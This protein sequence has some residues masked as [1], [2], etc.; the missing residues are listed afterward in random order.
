MVTNVG[1]TARAEPWTTFGLRLGWDGQL[2]R[3]RVVP[4]VS[5]LNLFDERY[6]SSVVV[7]AFGGRYFET[8]PGRHLIVG[9]EVGL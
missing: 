4:F 2:G 5:V 7:N 8:A 1:N 6:A 3:T 9:L